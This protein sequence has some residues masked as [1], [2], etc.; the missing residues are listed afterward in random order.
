MIRWE[1]GEFVQSVPYFTTAVGLAAKT[2]PIAALWLEIARERA[3]VP[4]EAQFAQIAA[5]LNP[6]RWPAPLFRSLP[7]KDHA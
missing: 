7:R 4:N 6:E 5:Q 2:D 3:G 1:N